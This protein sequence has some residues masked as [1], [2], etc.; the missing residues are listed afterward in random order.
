MAIP[1]VNPET[2]VFCPLCEKR[3]RLGDIAKE[4]DVVVCPKCQVPVR[5]LTDNRG[6]SLSGRR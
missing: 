4:P 2:V 6:S 3:Y 5:A 1:K